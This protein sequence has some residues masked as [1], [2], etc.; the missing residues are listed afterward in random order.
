[1][2]NGASEHITL[3]ATFSKECRVL[4]NA[5][6]KIQIVSLENV[7]PVTGCIWNHSINSHNVLLGAWKLRLISQ[8]TP[9]NGYML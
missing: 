8:I 6:E 3:D 9:L 5:Q 1:M 2:N 7:S 4:S